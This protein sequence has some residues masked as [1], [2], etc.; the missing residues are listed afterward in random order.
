MLNTPMPSQHDQQ[1]FMPSLAKRYANMVEDKQASSARN[2]P[3]AEH[4]CDVLKLV[5]NDNKLSPISQVL[6][7]A[8]Q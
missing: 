1:Q 6:S 3:Q 5:L 8:Q 4:V 7:R 2:L